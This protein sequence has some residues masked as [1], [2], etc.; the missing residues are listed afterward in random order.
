MEKIT[1]SENAALVAVEGL[2]KY[3]PIKGGVLKRTIGQVKA[4]DG[5][6][7][8]I[9]KREVL[10]I[11]GE[12]GCGKST[13]GRVMLRLQEPT[14]GR[15]L[16]EGVDL[17]RLSKEEMRVKR[18]QMQQIF[19]DPYAS[20]N[21]WM[22]VRDIIAEPL[23]A[24]GIGDQRERTDR[25]REMMEICGLS[26]KHAERYPHEF[27]GGQRQRICIARALILKPKFIVAD[28]PVSA[29][30]VSIRSQIINLFQELQKEFGL[31][32]M[33]ISHDL[34]VMRH[35]SDRIGIMYLGRMVELAECETLF[36]RP[37]H[38]Y[39]QALLSA[40]PVADPHAQRKRQI[41][42]GDVPSP[43]NAPAGCAF[44]S[45]CA[46]AM[47]I[48]TKERPEA[49]QCGTSAVACHLYA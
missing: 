1:Q 17:S 15:V 7:F 44:A 34:S 28:E 9:K 22:K 6:S 32:Y 33:F 46:H 20:L 8:E 18:R 25:V 10:G 2:K 38:P 36:E 13:T 49:R 45:R 5:V 21:P 23:F 41:L 39:T 3:Y 11:A 30:D 43:A 48:C 35:I 4:V 37:L 42:Q 12:S 29:L 47:P 19:Q 14:A 27:S 16:F 31:T 26:E 24:H 40:V